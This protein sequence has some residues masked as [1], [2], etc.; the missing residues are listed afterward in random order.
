MASYLK[1]P[2]CALSTPSTCL[3]YPDRGEPRLSFGNTFFGLPWKFLK[4]YPNVQELSREA[5]EHISK[6]KPRFSPF[7]ITYQFW[8]WPIP[9]YLK[10]PPC[11]LSTPSTCR[12]SQWKQYNTVWSKKINMNVRLSI[13]LKVFKG[14]RQIYMQMKAYVFPFQDNISILNL[15]NGFIP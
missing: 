11:A 7:R 9:S 1:D 12:C 8:I 6:W 5:D 2:P 3:C 4:L 15:A 13:S 10:H 14:G